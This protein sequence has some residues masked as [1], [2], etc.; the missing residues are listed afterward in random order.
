MAQEAVHSGRYGNNSPQTQ[1]RFMPPGSQP[2]DQHPSVLSDARQD[3][4]APTVQ[5]IMSRRLVTV[6]MDDSLARARELFN[7]FH[8][9]HLLVVEG[10]ELVGIISDR[11]LLKAVSPYVGTM[12]ETDRDRATLQKRVHQIMSRTLVT[13]T[14]HTSVMAASQLLLENRVSCLPVLTTAGHLEGIVTWR[15]LLREYLRY[16]AAA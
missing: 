15:D 14:L 1:E 3:E 9:H 4:P 7:E 12:S 2:S 5:A 10:R 8:F 13:V 11:D 16:Q 6:A